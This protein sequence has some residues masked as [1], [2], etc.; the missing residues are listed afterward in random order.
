MA[1]SYPQSST[2]GPDG[3]PS[4]PRQGHGLDVPPEACPPDHVQHGPQHYLDY[5]DGEL[6]EFRP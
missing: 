1:D 5:A 4:M 3:P 6:K 2:A